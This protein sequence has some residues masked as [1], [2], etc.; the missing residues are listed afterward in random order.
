MP[1]KHDAK[2]VVIIRSPQLSG[3]LSDTRK[4]PALAV[5]MLSRPLVTFQGPEKS[6]S[7]ESVNFIEL[8]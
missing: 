8:R 2:V 5:F 1:A 4:M 3:W 7:G 6:D